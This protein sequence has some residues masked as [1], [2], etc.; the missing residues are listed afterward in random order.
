MIDSLGGP[1]RVNKLLS[2]LNLK[3]V[4]N[5]S[6]KSMER[7]AGNVIETVDSISTKSAAREAFTKEME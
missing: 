3:S 6:L 7:R 2:T 1:V 5:K 4:G